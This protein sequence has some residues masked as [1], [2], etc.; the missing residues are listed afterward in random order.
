[1]TTGAQQR[2]LR[3]RDATGRFVLVEQS[4]R[5]STQTVG[6]MSNNQGQAGDTP[7]HPRPNP[8]PN[9][10]EQ[11][12]QNNNAQL[13]VYLETISN[14][15]SQLPPEIRVLFARQQQLV[16]KAK[17][18]AAQVRLSAI[19]VDRDRSGSRPGASRKHR[20]DISDYNESVNR[21]V[22]PASQR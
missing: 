18:K 7:P 16:A 21:L 10:N 11:E 6:R 14:Q 17:L 19:E 4:S 2:R 5:G 22:T 1:M 15:I 13:N 3:R 9:K 20:R 12:Q 8:N